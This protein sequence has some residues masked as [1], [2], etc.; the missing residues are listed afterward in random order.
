MILIG[1]G[2]VFLD[3]VIIVLLIVFVIFLIIIIL[4]INF[5]LFFILEVLFLN[6]GGMVILIGDLFNIMI[7]VVNF[8]FDFNVFLLNLIFVVLIIGVVILGI[9]VFIYC[10]KLK[11]EDSKK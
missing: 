3:N 1:V 11:V 7:G 4:N 9:F 10:K 2:L 8:Y 5:F 6:I